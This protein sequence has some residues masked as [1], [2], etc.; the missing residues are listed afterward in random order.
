VISS[1]GRD[2]KKAN[3]ALL[4]G[5]LEASKYKKVSQMKILKCTKCGKT[6]Q[7]GKFCFDCGNKLE[8]IITSQVI[9][10]PIDSNRTA[11]QL[12]RDVRTW[13][14][15]LGVQQTDI[16]INSEGGS[17]RI[18]YALGKNIYTFAS[19]LQN[20]ITNNLAAVE[21]FLHYRVLSIE[22]GIE[23]LEQ[24]F[25]GYEALPDF[26]DGAEFEPY[27][28]LG[29]TEKVSFQEANT[30]FKMLAKKY[31]PDVDKSEVSKKEFDR[32]RKAIQMIE[33]KL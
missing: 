3:Q 27:I 18:E 24:A 10:K 25:A 31:H 14:G 26:S 7:T 1:S 15:R 8:E 9:F 13:L 6:Q 28:A 17:A 5:L 29:F 32:I 33:E 4:P 16:K 11:D 19:H 22:R 30:R 20:N 12:K 2:G 23:T 21:Q